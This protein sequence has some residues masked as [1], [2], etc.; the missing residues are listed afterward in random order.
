MPLTPWST[1]RSVPAHFGTI[2]GVLA[3]VCVAWLEAAG[4]ASLGEGDQGEDE[5]H[6]VTMLQHAWC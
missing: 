4:M 2:R 3:P 1:K 5:R 6:M